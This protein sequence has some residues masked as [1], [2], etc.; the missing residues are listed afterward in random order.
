MALSIVTWTVM[1]ASIAVLWGT[2]GVALAKSL[3]DE[4][5]KLELLRKQ[6]KIDTYSPR[7]LRELRSWIESNPDDPLRDEAVRRHND[8][9]E[10]LRS[11]DEPFYEW[12]DEE[13]ASLDKL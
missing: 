1:L 9:V 4:D 7:G 10:S 6:E 2:S 13:I 8:C 12:T 5:R 3:R 11:I